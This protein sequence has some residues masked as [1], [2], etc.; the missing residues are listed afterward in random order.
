MDLKKALEIQVE[1]FGKDGTIRVDENGYLC[2]NDL[3]AYFPNK[4]IQ[5]WQENQATK[6]LISSVEEILIRRKEGELETSPMSAIV[7]KKGRYKSGTYAHELI[8]MDFAMWLSV[9]FRIHVYQSYINGTQHK[10]NW[11][12]KRILAANNYRV[13]CEAVKHAHDPAKHYHFSNEAKM[14]NTII[15]G[16]HEPDVRDTASE[17]QLNAIAWLESHNAAL[18][19]LG[20]NYEDRKTNLSKMYSEKYL[21]EHRIQLGVAS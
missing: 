6:E 20:M 5:H 18:I 11:N 15:F 10:Q 1:F 14:L 17:A 2:L 8:A 19:D 4:R 21:P 12:I 13:M 3:N 9:E 16:Q 7:G